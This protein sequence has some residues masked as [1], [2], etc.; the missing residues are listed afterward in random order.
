M[1]STDT[2]LVFTCNM[3]VFLSGSMKIHDGSL[4]IRE[5][6]SNSEFVGYSGFQNAIGEKKEMEKTTK[7]QTIRVV[8]LMVALEDWMRTGKCAV[9]MRLL[10]ERICRRS[11]ISCSFM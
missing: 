4:D 8:A 1:F 10:W 2:L 11:Y 7:M 9:W 5:C 6:V 3:F